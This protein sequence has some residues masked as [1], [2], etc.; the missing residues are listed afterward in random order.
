MPKV[1][2]LPIPLCTVHY[3]LDEYAVVRMGSLEY[4]LYGGHSPLLIS[5]DSKGFL[6]PED[7]AGENIPAERARVA[8]SLRFGQISL[9][10]SQFLFRPLA[11]RQSPLQL[12]VDGRK[13]SGPFNDSFLELACDPVLVRPASSLLQPNPRLICRDSP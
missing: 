1:E 6:R 12:F 8:Q 3:S 13:L 5:K 10:P 7:L 4:P 11:L 9:T 2:L